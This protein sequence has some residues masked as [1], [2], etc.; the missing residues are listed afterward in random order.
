VVAEQVDQ[1]IENLRLRR[2]Q[3]GGP[4]Q[5]APLHIQNIVSERKSHYKLSPPG[6]TRE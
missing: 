6:V 2:H 1:E 4:P 3:F 5:L